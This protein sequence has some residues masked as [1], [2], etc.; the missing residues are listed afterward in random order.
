MVELT[1]FVLIC[2][3][4]LMK[5]NGVTTLGYIEEV[6]DY[7]YNQK[8]DTIMP[9]L[10]LA[11][12]VNDR[13]SIAY[14]EQ[15]NA[16]VHMK[17]DLVR[18]H[19]SS[20]I[21]QNKVLK[22][23]IEDLIIESGKLVVCINLKLDGWLNE[24]YD[25]F[26]KYDSVTVKFEYHHRIGLLYDHISGKEDAKPQRDFATYILVETLLD[27]PSDFLSEYYL[28][29][30]NR[31]LEK[32]G[33]QPPRPRREVAE[34]LVALLDYQPGGIVYNPFAG[35]SFVGAMIGAGEKLYADGDANE[36]LLAIGRLL[37]YGMKGSNK[38][39]IKRDSTLWI[40]GIT[41]D[42]VTTT[43]RGY[44][45]GIPAFYFC[46]QKCMDSLSEKGKFAGVILP[47]DLFGQPFEEFKEIVNK[48]WLDTIV[49]FP[50]NEVAILVNKQKNLKGKVRLFN[51][52][53]PLLRNK[54]NAKDILEFTE[55]ARIITNGEIKRKKYNLKS[56][57]YKSVEGT[58]D[59]K[60]VGIRS[61]LEKIIPETYELEQ[62]KEWIMVGINRSV[63]YDREDTSKS[64]VKKTIRTMFKPA[65]QLKGNLIIVNRRHRE[66]LLEPRYYKENKD[67]VFFDVEEGLVFKLKK[68]WASEVSWIQNELCKPYVLEQLYPY[69]RDCLLPEVITEEKFL[70]LKLRKSKR[71]DTLA[72]KVGFELF[73]DNMIKYVIKDDMQRG[74]FGIPYL[75]EKI[76]LDN[77]KKEEVVLKEFFMIGYCYRDGFGKVRCQD[78]KLVG[79]YRAKFQK[80]AEI[81]QRL[82]E[83]PENHIMHVPRIFTDEKTG[84]LF[85]EMKNYKAGSLNNFCKRGEIL[86]EDFIIQHVV[87]PLT[88]AL[89]E[90]HKC[91]TLHLDV[92]P[93]NI[94]LDENND[95]ILIDFGIAKRYDEEGLELTEISANGTENFAPPE[96]R[97]GTMKRF[98]PPTDVFGLAATCYK[99]MTGKN[100]KVVYSN[101][102]ADKEMKELLKNCSEATKCALI[103][104]LSNAIDRRPKNMADFL[105]M[106]PGCET[107][108]L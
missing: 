98:T 53:D 87:I 31:M 62:G 104:A 21:Q 43:Y 30:F 13:L 47:K 22:K 11:L 92:K 14:S 51:M 20:F 83:N 9:L 3:I 16:R 55:G 84:S 101:S 107:I 5:N 49:L 34:M 28:H 85:Y 63:P 29:L 73:A 38:N 12:A 77:D 4:V 108:T 24:V 97:N 82:G 72:L 46:L 26:F 59:Y 8:P 79:E 106:F 80:E 76:N 70:S 33:I 102:D 18:M 103:K 25:L 91:K 56:F 44:P 60:L 89:H 48:D 74:S 10:L 65:Y 23:K 54:K 86:S 7:Y 75:A 39:F 99:L 2:R 69:G 6:I 57:F 35:C 105:H 19:S 78:E 52:M 66:G 96:Q 68:E 100:P 58:E 36:K 15:E 95:A 64:L 94:L 41:P 71:Q 61:V 88:K 37:N 90:V 93:S 67:N 50:F 32:S 45:N 40:E 27:L 81:M 17:Y 1:I 42:Y